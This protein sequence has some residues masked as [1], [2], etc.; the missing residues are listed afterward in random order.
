MEKPKRRK[1]GESFTRADRVPP[2]IA[3]VR[4]L[5]GEFYLLS[6]VAEQVGVSQGTLRKLVHADPPKVSAPSYMG[7]QG[8]MNIYL[9]TPEDVTEIKA[10]FK[11]KYADFEKPRGPGRPKKKVS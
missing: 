3:Y 5:D 8:D 1:A 7:N 9:F 6:E 10:Y 4:S 11:T 2:A